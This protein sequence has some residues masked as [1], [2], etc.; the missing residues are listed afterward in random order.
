MDIPTVRFT[1]SYSESSQKS[2]NYVLMDARYAE[3]T[4]SSG[5]FHYLL[6]GDDCLMRQVIIGFAASMRPDGLVESRYPSH[7]PQIIPGFALF[8][9]L[10]ICDHHL[11][12][13]DPAFTRRMLPLVD[14]TLAF[15]DRHI[16]ERGLVSGLPKRFWQFV[17][18]AKEW[19]GT[20]DY[21]NGGVPV[22]GRRSN[23]FTYTSM[24]LAYVLDQVATMAR[25]LDK[26][27]LAEDYTT[28]ADALRLA[29]AKHCFDGSF[30]C[31]STTD[32]PAKAYSQHTQV[33]AVL[34]KT[35]PP[36]G[37]SRLLRSAFGLAET[38]SPRFAKCSYVLM[39]YAFRAFAQTGRENY[40]EFWPTAWRP[41]KE[42]LR[43]NL[44]T[45][46]EDPVTQR[47]DC[48]AW[49]SVPIYEFSVEVAGLHVTS[50]GWRAMVFAP[51]VELSR[52]IRA[53]VAIGSGNSADVRWETGE[54][55]EI[56]ISLRLDKRIKVISRLPF[57]VEVDHGEI[58]H[59]ELVT[60]L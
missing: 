34:S 28:R 9:V 10:Q 22:Q 17:D 23:T 40:N 32:Q 45:W 42:M 29:V 55:G 54:D 20:T 1:S 58:D 26:P 14:Q 7:K 3:D 6:S 52:S 13:D 44:T 51:R 47:S 37:A 5:L 25:H 35:C 31:D 30:Y 60:T 11:F 49:G 48:H 38:F 43:K 12:F 19:A 56:A 50:P 33:F 21:P 2:K 27:Y 39:F 57:G 41:W 4:R 15:F 18:W 36:D 53:K 46:E 59:L 24:L 16:D 8:W